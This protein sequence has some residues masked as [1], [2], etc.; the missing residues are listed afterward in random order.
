MLRT[1]CLRGQP[2]R[3]QEIAIRNA[4]GASR[5]RIVRQLLTESALIAALGGAFGVALAYAGHNLL[6]VAASALPRSIASPTATAR[7][8]QA[9]ID[10]SVLLFTFGLSVLTGILFGLAPVMRVSGPQPNRSLQQEITKQFVGKNQL[11]EILVVS[12]I[13]LAFVLLTGAGLLFA[14]S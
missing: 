11:R 5:G 8:E 1:C 2:R 14:A 9:G 4:L 13:A 7:I 3:G 6:I 10:S 12:E